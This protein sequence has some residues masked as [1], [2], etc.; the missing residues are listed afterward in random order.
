VLNASLAFDSNAGPTFVRCQLFFN[1]V[2]EFGFNNRV[3][4]AAGATAV[5]PLTFGLDLAVPT[6][7]DARCQSGLA[8]GVVTQPSEMA[9]IRVGSLI[10]A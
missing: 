7:V 2:E 6:T 3:S 4:I 8:S 5:M 10:P 9:M 1:G